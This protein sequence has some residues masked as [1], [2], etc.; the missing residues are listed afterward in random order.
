MTDDLFSNK[1][2]DQFQLPPEYDPNINY[3]E[4][5][6]GEGKKFHAPDEKEAINKLAFAKLESDRFVDHLK[7]EQATLRSD[8][9]ARQRLED[10]VTKLGTSEQNK[11]APSIEDNQE[12]ERMNTV[13]QQNEFK[14]LTVEEVDARLDERM[15]TRA[16]LDR[17]L[18]GLK[19]VYGD[20]Y[21][22][23]LDAEAK[24]LN[25]DKNFVNNLA[26]TNPDAFLRMFVRKKTQEDFMAPPSSN[27]NSPMSSGMTT[28]GIK[29]QKF[30]EDLKKKDPS[31]YWSPKVQQQEYEDAKKLGPAFF[32]A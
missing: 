24:S 4:Q 5:L 12:Q 29:N 10:L 8:L 19:S 16:N 13:N 25:V 31:V 9:M 1:N 27:I 18:A 7:R 6:V 21:Q 22:T 17:A 28:N 14:G 30:Y 23:V 32:N 3:V 2:E 20:N 26:K 15:R 11:Q